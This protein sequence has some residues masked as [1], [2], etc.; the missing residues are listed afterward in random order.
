MADSL[1]DKRYRYD[2]IYP[3]GRSGETLR[4]VD[5][6]DGDRKVVIKR[7]ASVDAPPIRNGQEVSI[8]NERRALQR[9]SGH[10]VLSAL[11]GEGQFFVQ[12]TAHQYIVIERAEGLVLAEAISELNALGTRLPMLE[13]LVIVDNLLDLLTFAHAKGIV[14]NDVDSKHLF[15]NRDTYQL[16]VIDWGNAVQ[17]DEDDI[18]PQG[19]SRQSDVFQVG[20]LLYH[21]VTGGRRA[22]VPKDA[23]EHF[24]VDFGDDSRRV[25][26][27]LQEIISK[28]LHPNPRLRYPTIQALRADLANFRAPLE[29]ERNTTVA[30]VQERLKR[31][32]LSKGE[33]RTLKTMIET[34][35]EQDPGFPLARHIQENILDRLRDLS[36][37]ADLDATRS[38]IRVGA[39]E[40]ARDLLAQLRDKG[41]TQTGG[42]IHFLYDVC[43]LFL[44]S[45]TQ[46][47]DTLQKAI[48]LMMAGNPSDAAQLLVRTPAKTEATTTLQWLIAERISSHLPD[49]LLLRPNLLRISTALSQLIQQGY[50]VV[51]AQSVFTSVEKTLELM[52]AGNVTLPDLRDGYR[53]VAEQL[54]LVSPILQTFAYQQEMTG[55]DVPLNS[56]DRALNAAM[57]LTDSMHVIGKQATSTHDALNALETAIQ[58][59]PTNPVW[60]DVQYLLKRL[61]ERL[62]LCQI[63]VPSADGSDVQ[64]WLLNVRQELL[65]FTTRLFD[66]V[67]E[68]MVRGL[69][70]AGNA[71]ETYRVAVILGNREDALNALSQ[72]S[73]SV[74]MLS[75]TL[76]GWFKNLR[77]VVEGAQY[78]ERHSVP[79]G[80]GRALA[81]GWE[82][83]DRGRL[84]DSERLGQQ[85]FEI[86]RNDAEQRASDRLRLLG[87]FT[88]EWVER[89]AIYAPKR[90][91]ELL[92]AVEGLLIADERA[93]LDNFT[94][95]MPSIETYLK[96]MS[97]GLVEVFARRSSSGLRL[98]MVRYLLLGALD[99]QEG[100]LKD[101]EFWREAAVRVLGD[102]ATR[103]IATRTLDDYIARKHDLNEAFTLLN[104]VNGRQALPELDDVR[105]QLENNPQAKTLSGGIQAL[106]EVDSALRDWQDGEFRTASLKLEQAIKALGDVEQTNG[107]KLNGTRAWLM[108]LMATSAEL[109]EKS[110]KMRQ[111]IEQRPDTPDSIVYEAHHDLV[112]ITTKM[113]GENASATLRQWR[114]TYDAFLEAYTSDERRSKRLERMNELFRAMFIDRHP[115]YGLYRHWYEVLSASP[116]FP[117]PP[118]NDPTP[119]LTADSPVTIDDYKGRYS[120]DTPSA[121]LPRRVS[122]WTLFAGVAV[123]AIVL[124]GVF[125]ASQGASSPVVVTISPTP[126]TTATEP[127]IAVMSTV[128]TATP[129]PTVP[130]A[131][132]T[133]TPTVT[134]TVPTP[135][136]TITPT[137]T[138]TVPTATLTATPTIPTATPTVM[139]TREPATTTPLP[140][141]GIQGSQDLLA[142]FTQQ[143]TLPFSADVF[144]PLENGYRLG[145]GT[146]GT[147]DILRIAPSAEWLNQAYGNNA[148]SRVRSTSV[149]LTLRTFNP[150]IVGADDVYF[151]VLL[152][153]ANDG[154]N[155][156]LQVQVVNTNVINLYRVVNNERT[157]LSQ[158]SVN[159]VIA[160][161]RLD[162]DLATGNV[163]LFYND[164]VLGDAVRF[165]APELP[166]VPIVYVKE[167]GVVVGVTNWRVVLR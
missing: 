142:L 83:F 109:Q 88:R 62:Q 49:I 27:R 29:R 48:D 33:L 67:L 146:A 78:I 34:A 147:A 63:Y 145:I 136:P 64:A 104:R 134:P 103:H 6:Q 68:Q 1:F 9:L 53:S 108:E 80:L 131:T 97:R 116:E 105:R 163:T 42:L 93:I 13:I 115:A 91:Q 150:A 30:T 157:F 16:K 154:N 47:T 73:D 159:V 111:S 120:E 2:Y 8:A 37:E 54:T 110:R 107:F 66:D 161:L 143:E 95:Q 36:V 149:E 114:D 35:L 20:Q 94:Q 113:L 82:A 52:G 160:R 166:I 12:G 32:D 79:N 24:A 17:L 19:I 99:A 129:T 26:S 121:P 60:E 125:L 137:I 72:A 21:V 140:P 162:R 117:A 56:L 122:L 14:Y 87:Q 11:L 96:A 128:E 98:L 167:G 44:K 106:R 23:P 84:S 22:D 100:R 46:D 57:S 5:T 4:A 123:V 70:T 86:A 45:P 55:R 133:I 75:P 155:V 41:G 124:V 132:P 144:T 51:E 43:D 112:R 69:Q 50:E 126:T 59:D 138:P 153:S 127:S 119:R 92:D 85:A 118:T 31:E 165:V 74:S 152:E 90:T 40:R 10:P 81:E 25:H 18:T 7:P 38:Y 65:P 77:T 15:W 148:P 158:R 102:V 89:N 39:W 3:R 61:W 156:G 101:A 151:G 28:S 76:S 58:I 135:T 71:W 164:E 139:P 141:Q 130:T